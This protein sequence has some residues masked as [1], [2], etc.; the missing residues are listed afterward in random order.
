M[1]NQSSFNDMMVSSDEESPPVKSKTSVPDASIA[2]AIKSILS[3]SLQLPDTELE[4]LLRTKYGKNTTPGERWQIIKDTP[5]LVNNIQ[6]Q[7]DVENRMVYLW[8]DEIMLS[9]D[10]QQLDNI[11]REMFKIIHAATTK[12]MKSTWLRSRLNITAKDNKRALKRLEEC[13]LI[14]KR[15]L[16]KRIFYHRSDMELDESLTGGFWENENMKPDTE[17]IIIAR[18]LA[19]QC[20]ADRL[21]EKQRT[22]AVLAGLQ[23]P[24]YYGGCTVQEIKQYITMKNVFHAKLSDND[25]RTLMETMRYDDLVNKHQKRD[26][27][28]YYLTKN[29]YPETH[30]YSHCP[31]STCPVKDVCAENSAVNPKSCQYLKEWLDD[32]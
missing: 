27:V 23:P 31:C 29:S 3:E 30:G 14:T 10:A 13:Q 6:P 19:A 22:H 12:G 32:F 24:G 4:K 20:L 15:T 5:F 21:A 1:T 26:V 25:I 28:I 16:G 17:A 18:K 11:E 9:A 2:S 7:T 8:K